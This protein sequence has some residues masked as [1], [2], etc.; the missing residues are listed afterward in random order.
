[1]RTE[2]D[3]LGEVSVPDDA[4]YG[5][6]TQRAKDNFPVGDELL[7]LSFIHSLSLVKEV[8]AQVN[9]DLSLLDYKIAAAISTAAQEV[10]QG[11]LPY[12]SF[13]L[14][15]W[16]SGS[17]TQTNMN[18]NEVLANRASEILGGT[19]GDKFPVHPNDHVNMG[20]S[21][22]DIFPTA[23]HVAVVTAIRDQLY[24]A[25]DKM[26]AQLVEKSLAFRHI[27][28]IG[29]THLQDA[30]P[31]TLGQE[32]SGYASQIMQG[33]EA[34][35]QTMPELRR[36]AVGGTA[37]G[38]GINTHPDFGR[39][40]CD[41][42]Q[43]R[44]GEEFSQQSNLFAGISAHDGVVRMSGQ[45]R[46]LASSLLKIA[47]DIRFLG[48]GPRCGLGELHLPANEPGSSI[49]PGKVNPTQ[50]EMLTMVCCK[51]YGN[52]AAIAMAGSQGN[53]ELNVYKPLMAHAVLQSVQLLSDAINAFCDHCLADIA[54]NEE[55]IEKHVENSLMLVTALNPHIG[56]DKAAAIALQAWRE[57][58]TLRDVALESGML[59]AEQFDAWVKPEAMI[60]SAEASH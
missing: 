45:L 22:N 34:V 6:Q 10:R 41:A 19:R 5:A 58:R 15:V 56:Y 18:M 14:K 20:Q 16:Q 31:L 11:Q 59:T 29:R 54:A 21:T 25:L 30:T 47:N 23:L 26:I 51:I 55:A 57:N 12:D 44:T 27:V 7:P 43:T 32:F 28:K 1:M 46:A 39:K 2:K 38:T 9:A 42:L 17:G 40:V 13:P 33:L 48:S 37:V 49:M 24:P 53:F 50:C 52:D 35:Q 8:A 4:Y 3:A 60:T 36:L